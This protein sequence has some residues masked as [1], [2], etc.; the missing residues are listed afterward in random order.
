VS[1]VGADTG[2]GDLRWE[3]MRPAR[4]RNTGCRKKVRRKKRRE[5]RHGPFERK[6]K[7]IFERAVKS[8][9]KVQSSLFNQIFNDR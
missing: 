2:E 5:R 4:S 9:Q 1:W 3:K 6:I 8:Y 7:G